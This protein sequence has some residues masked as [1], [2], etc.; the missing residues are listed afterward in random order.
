[1][2]ICKQHTLKS[3]DA[4]NK[5]FSLRRFQT[6]VR[7]RVLR[8]QLCP[9]IEPNEIK[10]KRETYLLG[11]QQ[12]PLGPLRALFCAQCIH[13]EMCLPI[14]S[15]IYLLQTDKIK[16]G[17]ARG[18]YFLINRMRMQ[19]EIGK[20]EL[21]LRL[22]INAKRCCQNGVFMYQFQNETSSNILKWLWCDR[23]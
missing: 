12:T 16:L 13:L 22:T 2:A 18:N 1:M 19:F 8:T 5:G 14:E 21:Q 7:R 10:R 15:C 20:F 11:F 3:T 23:L 6:L 4:N 17:I 9:R